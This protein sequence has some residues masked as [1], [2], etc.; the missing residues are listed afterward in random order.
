MVAETID[1]VISTKELHE[2]GEHYL[3]LEK[4][5]SMELCSLDYTILHLRSRLALHTGEKALINVSKS[6]GLGKMVMLVNFSV[7]N[8][9]NQHLLLLPE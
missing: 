5:E 8:L 3:L 6:P 9:P 1:L 7:L 2:F 4:S